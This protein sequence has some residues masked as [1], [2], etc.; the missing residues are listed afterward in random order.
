MHIS[1]KSPDDVK[2]LPE[3]QLPELAEQLRA[4][5]LETVD[6]NGGH[7]ASN[8]GVVE[9][10]I[11]LLRVFSPPKDKILFDVGHQTYAYKLLTERADR[12]E[13]IRQLDGLSGFQRR[14]ESPYDAFGAGHAGT[15]LSAALGLAAARDRN[16]GDEHVVAVIGDAS[17]A[18]GTSLEALNN[19]RESTGKIIVI[20][21]DN[22][23]SISKNVG[24]LSRYFGRVLVSRRYNRIKKQ[25]ERVSSQRLH[26][27][28]L[29]RF[30][31]GLESTLKSLFVRNT[32]FET[33][34]LRYVGPVDG[35]NPA[36][37]RRALELARNDDRPVL[38]H[39]V[40]T[41]GKGY[42][43]AEENPSAW[44]GSAPFDISGQR[45][46]EPSSRAS[47][48]T[49]FGN[50]LGRLAEKDSRIV[51]I[52]AA[53]GDGC[54]LSDFAERFPDRCF[55]VGICESHQGTFA[56]GLAAGGLRPVVAIYSTFLQR[57]IDA[58]IHDAA[59]QNLPVVYCLDR[60]GVVAADGPTHHGVFDIALLRSVPN[61]TMMQPRNEAEFAQMLA[62][63]MT[64]EGPSVIRYPRGAGDSSLIPN[65]IVPLPLG[66]AEIIPSATF[67][68]Q[69]PEIAIWALGDMVPLA[70]DV[71]KVL[72]KNGVSALLVNARFIK[73]L[74]TELLQ[75]QAANGIRRFVTLEN[76]VV[77]GGFGTAFLEQSASL[78]IDTASILRIGWP[79][80]FIP[81]AH[82]NSHLFE[83]YG[84]T[85]EEI[86]AKILGITQ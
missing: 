64:L 31:Y 11:E 53:M 55:D 73:P 13:S 63:A 62:T 6:R 79:D 61:L 14:S 28:G 48:S 71:I 33:F 12:F 54:G 17:L 77:A 36:V 43:P 24:A 75:Q 45:N 38:L 22:K 83:R 56:A 34:G 76:G 29:R 2:A 44:H 49:T 10:T 19:V 51:A 70:Q 16:G 59:L 81:H 18:N 52:T 84:L 4:A 9:L 47:Y 41:K 25:I 5:I 23:M 26:L 3:A 37:L 68:P 15:A 50:V 69:K 1:A 66:K 20:L 7:L 67:I 35:H 32:F 8:L 21:N 72:E 58:L 60:A 40:T 82:A 85:A 30:Y 86:A 78:G 46:A 57:S 80:E 42:T 65:D 39:V 74:D 27:S